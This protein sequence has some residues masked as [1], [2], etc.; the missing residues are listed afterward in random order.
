LGLTPEKMEKRLRPLAHQNDLNL[1][2]RQEHV[3][4]DLLSVEGPDLILVL[5]PIPDHWIRREDLVRIARA[6]VGVVE[7]S[8]RV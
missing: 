4:G 8:P 2:I 6:I 1:S 5:A 3:S 7:R